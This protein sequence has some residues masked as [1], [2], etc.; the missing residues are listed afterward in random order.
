[1]SMFCAFIIEPER[2]RTGGGAADV[3][4]AASQAVKIVSLHASTTKS[5]D[6]PDADTWLDYRNRPGD[7]DD[8][9][10]VI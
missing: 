5:P 7:N 9:V 6:R 1:M 4:T 10:Q 3:E 2:R 8:L